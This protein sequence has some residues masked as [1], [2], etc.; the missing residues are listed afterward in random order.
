MINHESRICRKRTHQRNAGEKNE[1]R[2]LKKVKKNKAK[3]NSFL[4]KNMK[5]ARENRDSPS[6]RPTYQKT[7]HGHD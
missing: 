3:M 5:S 6:T 7:T 4:R 1:L 2:S